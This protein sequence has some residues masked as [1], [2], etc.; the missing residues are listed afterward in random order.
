MPCRHGDDLH[1]RDQRVVRLCRRDGAQK[2]VECLARLRL[3]QIMKDELQRQRI[4]DPKHDAF[5]PM[6]VEQASGIEFRE[7][8]DQPTERIVAVRLDL[9]KYEPDERRQLARAQRQTSDHAEAATAAALQRP[10]QVGVC[11]GIGKAH[12][13]IGGHDFRFQ[14][15][16]TR[17][18]IPLREAAEPVAQHMP[19]NA[20]GRAAA[21]LHISAGRRRHR[22]IHGQPARPGSH[23]HG[24]HSRQSTG[25][26]VRNEAV[27]Q[28]HGIHRPH[29]HKQRVRRIRA[30]E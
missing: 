13:A 6:R 10:E 5:A 1:R 20:H 2:R 16:R 15:R 11:A 17:R 12:G 7:A 23:R 14:Q 8:C 9:S 24:R 18:A 21:A 22:V 29:P 26:S 3:G 25:A 30:A 4:V 19:G 27:V 28:D